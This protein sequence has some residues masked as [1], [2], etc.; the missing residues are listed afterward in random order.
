[1]NSQKKKILKLKEIG[2][3]YEIQATPKNPATPSPEGKKPVKRKNF[4][5]WLEEL[6]KFKEVHGHTRVPRHESEWKSLGKWVSNVRSAKKG[7]MTL[8]L[9]EDQ[10]KQLDEIGFVWDAS[11]DRS[12]KRRK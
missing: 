1:M 6:K 12:S 11:D 10:I 5:E 2:F 4:S 8:K 9:T 3:N 7:M